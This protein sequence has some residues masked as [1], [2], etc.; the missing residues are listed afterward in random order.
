MGKVYKKA[1]VENDEVVIKPV[2]DFCWTSDHRLIDGVT[3]AKMSQDFEKLIL[4][5]QQLI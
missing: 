2:I 4:S 3:G 5:P 1:V